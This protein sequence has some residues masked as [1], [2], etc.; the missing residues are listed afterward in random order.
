MDAILNLEVEGV[1]VIAFTVSVVVLHPVQVVQNI[2]HQPYATCDVHGLQHIHQELII[3]S[4]IKILR[5]SRCEIWRQ[6]KTS[7][8]KVMN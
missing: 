6:K 7:K 5:G 3:R 4:S 8:L 2:V 1:L